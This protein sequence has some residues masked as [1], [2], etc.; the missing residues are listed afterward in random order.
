M[1]VSTD[2]PSLDMAYKL[3]EYDGRPRLKLSPDKVSLVGRKQVFRLHA[4]DGTYARDVIGLREETADSVAHEA[5]VAPDRVV[6]LLHPVMS[7]GRVS[8]S[9]AHLTR[10]SHPIPRRLCA[11]PP[12]D[13]GVAP[14]YSVFRNL[15]EDAHAMSTRNPGTAYRGFVNLRLTKCEMIQFRVFKKIMATIRCS[16]VRL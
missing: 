12:C 9:I 5:G 11:P 8:S 14:H 1:G 13:P 4:P 10:E 16:H 2:A 15:D 7:Q 6:P 3:V